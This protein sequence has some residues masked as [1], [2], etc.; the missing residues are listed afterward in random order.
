MSFASFRN[1]LV[2]ILL[3]N[4]VGR[5][6]QPARPAPERTA[7][8]ALTSDPDPGPRLRGAALV[9]IKLLP[10]V[11]SVEGAVDPWSLF[12]GDQA[13]G[14]DSRAR[15]TARFGGRELLAGIRV[16]GR[17]EGKLQVTASFGDPAHTQPLAGLSAID[18]SSAQPD[19]WNSFRAAL[20]AP[21][22]AVVIEWQPA[23]P[24]ARL[25]ELELWG[26]GEGSAA[27]P[28]LRRADQLLQGLPPGA[29]VTR[30]VP[31]EVSISRP[32]AAL[33][34]GAGR[35][36]ARL[37]LDPRA[38]GRAFLVYEL[39][40]LSGWA[41]AS[42]RINAQAALGPRLAPEATQ[43]E[44]AMLQVEE[45][46]LAALRRG[47]N[48]IQFLPVSETDP[49][50]YRVQ[51]AR[52]VV[53]PDRGDPLAGGDAVGAT[54]ARLGALF[55][56]NLDTSVRL[57]AHK[58]VMLPFARPAQPESISFYLPERS[59]GALAVSGCRDQI[60]CEEASIELDGLGVGWHT[61][62]LALGPAQSLQVSLGGASEPRGS[63]AELA[64]A[65]SGLP[66]PEPR[67]VLATPAGGQCMRTQAYV[68]GFALGI[69]SSGDAQLSLD[70]KPLALGGDGAFE[71]LVDARG[72]KPHAI[73]LQL[74]T[75][76]AR[77]QQTL[78]LGPCL[79]PRA[80]APR[81][82][83]ED[84]GA[85]FAKWVHAGEAATVQL[86]DAR[87]D[88]PAGAVAEDVRITI[89]PLSAAEA[90]PLDSG[91]TNVGPGGGAYRLG[92]HGLTF[93]KPVRLTL[94]YG[95]LPPGSA[96][97]E[98]HTF[99]FDEGAG[100][101]TRVLRAAAPEGG[102]TVA[103]TQHFTDFIN[104]TLAVPD[105]PQAASFNPTS[106]KEMK[107]GDPS[108][109]VTL[110]QPPAA[111][112]SGG[113][114]L[115]Y[116][117]EVPRGR[118]GIEPNLAVS[119]G[120]ERQNGWLGLGWD[121]HLS[122]IQVDTRFG[123]PR[124]DGS[125]T[126][127]L[128]G[129]MLAPTGAVSPAGGRLYQRRVEGAFERIERFGT[130]PT[131]YRFVVTDKSGLRRTY[132]KSPTTRL[133][134]PEAGNIFEWF[135]ERVEDPFGNFLTV[136]YVTDA[137]TNGD[138]Y[139]Q[140]GVGQPFVQVY[141]DTIGYTAHT[142]TPGGT[143][144]L[145]AHYSVRFVL[146]ALQSGGRAARPDVIITARPGFQVL[147]RHRL[148]HVE[149]RFDAQVV[150][151]YTFEYQTGEFGKSL[152][153]A[154]AMRGLDGTHEMYR[155][156]FEYFAMDRVG[157]ALAG[158]EDAKLFNVAPTLRPSD[159]LSRT[160]DQTNGGGG[161]I[162]IGIGP[163]SLSAGGGAFGGDDSTR[164]GVYVVTGD[165]LPGF[166]DDA[167]NAHV[168]SLAPVTGGLFATYTP[169]FLTGV[170]DAAIG[171]TN[172]SGW[173]VDGSLGVS[174]IIGLGASY[175]R[176]KMEDDKILVDMDGDGFVDLISIDGGC[177]HVLLNDHGRGFRPYTN[178][179]NGSACWGDLSRAQLAPSHSDRAAAARA[180]LFLV[181]PLVR[182]V[183]PIDGDVV[184]TGA[185]QKIAAGGDGVRAQI[186]RDNSLL[187]QRQVTQD[188][189]SACV[190]AG[191]NGCGAGLG[192][193]VAAGD[194]LY[195]KTSA[196]DDTTK[197]DLQ[198]NPTITY[199][200]A[201]ALSSLRE[202]DG[203][204]IYR[205]AQA[206][207]H[208]LAG[209]PRAEWIAAAQGSVHIRGQLTKLGTSDDVVLEVVKTSPPAAPAVIFSTPLLAAS[210]TAGT[211]P[212]DV[213]GDLTV[214]QGDRLELR[215]R[216]EASFDPDRAR[217][218]AEIDY[219]NFC[220]S[221]PA[222]GPVCGPVVCTA[223][224]GKVTCRIQ[225]DPDPN[226]RLPPAVIAQTA[227]VRYPA[228]VWRSA[229][230]FPQQATRAFVAPSSG[231]HAITGTLFPDP[232]L[233]VT[234]LVQGVHRLFYK[235]VFP[236]GL[237]PTPIALNIDAA[238][239]DELI[240][241]VYTDAPSLGPGLILA[242]DGAD[243]SD[244]VNR[245]HRDPNLQVD[246][247]TQ[248]AQNPM[249]GGWHRF[250]FGD[251]DGNLAFDESQ[252]VL[253]DPSSPPN[254]LPFAF[255]V[256]AAQ[257]TPSVAARLWAGRGDAYIAAGQQ[258]PSRLATTSEM[259]A[260]GGLKDLRV[261]TT[262]NVQLS[263]GALS[264]LNFDA[265]IGDSNTELDFIDLNGDGYPDSI[266]SDGV[267]FNDG[268]GGFAPAAG[269]PGLG[270]D[271]ALRQVV[272][273]SA[274]V[275]AGGSANMINLGG[276]SAETKKF[277]SLEF[278]AGIDY[279]LS[280]TE[281]DLVDLNGDGL[282]DQ[283]RTDSGRVLVRLNLGYRFGQEF[284]WPRGSWST[285]RVQDGIGAALVDVFPGDLGTDGGVRLQDTGSNSIGGGVGI[286][287]I[288]SAGEGVTFTIARSYT[289]LADINGD[290]L[291]DQLM[292]LPGSPVLLV[293]LNLGDHFDVERPW[294]VPVSWGTPIDDG[295]YAFFDS[296]QDALAFRRSESY[297]ASASGGFCIG[298]CFGGSAFHS[299]GSGSAHMG[300]ED[301]DGDGKLDFVL[302][303]DGE[304]NLRVKLNRVGKSNLLKVVHRPV[305][306]QFELEY[307]R[308][309]NHIADSDPSQR[310][311]MPHERWVLSQ[312]TTRDGMGT[313]YP[314]HIDYFASGFYDRQEREDYG[315]AHVR[316][317]REDGSTVEQRYHNQDYYR[318]GLL[319]SQAEAD[320]AGRLFLAT[321]TQYAEPG[322]QPVRTGSFFPAALVETTAFYEGTTNL[323]SAP[324][325]TMQTTKSY[326]ALGNLVGMVDGGDDGSA[327]DVQYTIGYQQDLAA[328]II[329]ASSIVARDAN[330]ALLRERTA[331]YRPDGALDVLSG[332]LMGGINPV[333]GT[334]YTG[335]SST[336]PTWHFD[337]DPLG[338]RTRV[339]DPKGFVVIYQYDPTVGTYVIGVAD[340]FG[341]TSSATYDLRF[342]LPTQT[343][344]LNGNA[345]QLEFDEFGRTTAT[346]GP[347]DIGQAEP[348][349][350]F[351][352]GLAPGVVPTWART[353]H[354][355]VANPGDPIDTVTF[356]DGLG[357]LIQTKK[358][359]ER[360]NG[361]GGTTV[362]MS[363]SGAVQFDV[364]GR[365][366][367]QGQ[368]TF[369]T[370][371]ALAFVNAPPLRPTQFQY[372]ILGR[373]TQTTA[374]DA[375]ITRIDYGFDMLDGV[376]R[377]AMTTTDAN[378]KQR[379][380]LSTVRKDTAAVVQY[381][382]GRALT[383][384]YGYDPLSE[385][386]T[387]TDA[388][389][390]A[391][392]S[393]FDTLGQRIALDNPDSGRTEY[394][395]D[396]GGN[397]AA[398]QTAKLRALGQM[399]NYNYT[400]N[401]L[402]GIDYPERTDVAYQYGAPG[403]TDNSAGRI[404]QITDESGT[405]T[406]SY[407]KLGEI[408]RSARALTRRT[409]GQAPLAAT[410]QYQ[411]DSFGRTL[412][413]IY[414]DGE[415]LTNQYD[416]GGLLTRVTGVKA[417]ASFT[418]VDRLTYDEFEQRTSI[419]YG[420]GVE[421][422]YA[423]DPLMRRLGEVRTN[424]PS[425]PVQLLH[426]GYDPVGNITSRTNDIPIPPTN[427]YGGPSAQ[428]FQY[429]DRYQLVGATG[430]YR[431]AP[432]KQQRYTL[433]M[434]YDD[435]G[436]I[437][438][439]T[440]A[441]AVVQPSG[442]SVP[443][444]GTTYDFAYAYADRPHAPAH[445]GTRTYH[446]D[447]SGNQT[448]WD[449]D[450][451][452]QRR[453]AVWNEDNQPASITDDGHE[454]DF[455]YDAAGRRTHEY[456]LEGEAIYVNQFYTVKNGTVLTKHVFAGAQR[457]ASKRELTG[458]GPQNVFR[459]FYHP[460]QIGSTSD[461]TDDQGRIYQHEE[462]FP[463]GESWIS[464]HSTT[465]RA[466][467]LFSGKE[468]DPELALYYYGARYYDPRTSVWQNVDPR[469]AKSKPA[470]AQPE[471]LAV[472]SFVRQNPLGYV[473]P[474][475]EDPIFTVW[476]V[477]KKG[478]VDDKILKQAAAGMQKTLNDIAAQSSN[479]AVKD[480]FAVKILTNGKDLEKEKLRLG[481]TDFV[482]YVQD[483]ITEEEVN[484]VFTRH[485]FSLDKDDTAKTVSTVNSGMGINWTENYEKSGEV[486]NSVS[487]VGTKAVNNT[488]P[489]L[490]VAGLQQMMTHEAVGHT[491]LGQQHDWDDLM[492]AVTTWN[493]KRPP[494]TFFTPDHQ[495]VI[496]QYLEG[497][498]QEKNK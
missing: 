483:K 300:L 356:V 202:A 385:L 363:V 362:G 334:P 182:W 218:D 457:V 371:P 394:R 343:V 59:S 498:A 53:I 210:T 374:P 399:I 345:Q 154:I 163:L 38:A 314:R 294:A 451:N 153:S 12:D 472:F 65:A 489:D 56:S 260:G 148:D 296:T 494:K 123:V 214:A 18:L 351:E 488:Y 89:R 35:L 316:T 80:P 435:I 249:S 50:G 376:R 464:E 19:R 200:V 207:D 77:S 311:D 33:V 473:D 105:H 370:G 384:R 487:F 20:A 61:V 264:V 309:G 39:Q 82:P 13:T 350:A 470:D 125:E 183:A 135:V 450:Q 274:G 241:T 11:L 120:S 415:V 404:V 112:S 348:T 63:I 211:V 354:K 258:K 286:P 254:P 493:P 52:L 209:P 304:P 181:D 303:K 390:H 468:L 36:E 268:Q 190:P 136:S 45:I 155:H 418:Y 266:A 23:R 453:T 170:D 359:L 461:V 490:K 44:Q 71:A 261:A 308:E 130:G 64:V 255:A 239:G 279:G 380:V 186:Y 456:N 164:M 313:S 15:I 352:Y 132:G 201:P 265:N 429:D 88:I 143:A 315:F 440:Q 230:E 224:A 219:T 289:E 87:L 175:T 180:R 113:A 353:R 342:G 431:E 449:D 245:R 437:T 159:G 276:T 273:R 295:N 109:G 178:P 496:L 198:W 484:T 459:F 416:R 98:I 226:L 118:G 419:R 383:T 111:S 115:S 337:Y 213:P 91:L 146:D 152:L 285:S 330:G 298:I 74:Q 290:G 495:K 402:D 215:V 76:T 147:T 478:A 60:H 282:P 420:N 70:G 460:D 149:M 331:H 434:S 173:H 2:A 400:F 8:R 4:L 203:S 407:G 340:S 22:D 127:L 229:E 195:F 392:Q 378:G 485:N 233:P 323:P 100:R 455:R 379:K 192:L 55:D 391:T 360:D 250:W 319:Q 491:I 347:Y 256:P 134:D 41:A 157:G 9:E 232:L 194:R 160:E 67:L 387:M 339:T 93:K 228:F 369:D 31:D 10:S 216:S 341:Y 284:E 86:G 169:L 16:F 280:Q 188:D 184:I 454:T 364:R 430:I 24:G 338:N 240:F 409:T 14:I 277:L 26:I 222:T 66:L 43:R 189:L 466:V 46:P 299:E 171:H 320:A 68:R 424:S 92:P 293:K 128:D 292:R 6:R 252:I 272:N 324:G 355:D 447:P 90:P 83:R 244:R 69:P 463:F 432:G 122:S 73:S 386:V 96:A 377:L 217:W 32:E 165:G 124:Y 102:R 458:G 445:I 156:S 34:A 397:V 234:L 318:H 328:Y 168:S 403:A 259:P 270:V 30:A 389:G 137:G 48:V 426:F 368:P 474:D 446:Y 448:G 243:A 333:T 144:D 7:P 25:G 121:L 185:L 310:E 465:D 382:A 306:G 212:F 263:V 231:T 307:A 142:Q 106:I 141:P 358:D 220:R 179:V 479:K 3:A 372:D 199:Q 414:P 361:G 42:R 247:G 317:T 79:P 349:I 469:L 174:G 365:I 444:G 486:A 94:P 205:F 452:G 325:K 197:D 327:D 162:G 140:P 278:N 406:R 51:H 104:A 237:L 158:F 58:Q 62:S 291:P 139:G 305:G 297:T 477:G 1:T 108:A 321:T 117:L 133:V 145:S 366:S 257:G 417:G 405:E 37:D 81:G 301:I 5:T 206:D 110:I 395:Y 114:N 166:L 97:R 204:S 411:Y 375:T 326:D 438:H 336:N 302:K 138:L 119:Y 131:D 312:V 433:S 423:Y 238:A 497:V 413:M 388:N 346:R 443:Q 29:I 251:W 367:A 208:R 187:W 85:P 72:P 275:N 322:S 28:D 107:L 412:S 196:I 283:I 27:R 221:N 253:P 393:T 78:A 248:V 492:E 428:T 476:V 235:Q 54:D 287:G 95:E 480:G 193:H 441:D 398:I 21:V 47:E 281:V 267:R 262:W 49:I 425:A 242:I 57:R 332:T 129:A 99:Y 150:R 471:L 246:D 410:S 475:G 436:N 329:H 467:Y 421:T 167:G 427:V 103:L 161:S 396:L 101:W 269:V 422:R 223:V 151:S 381:S 236:P 373:Q 481:K 177:V 408:V 482:V 176:T 401:R 344:D 357:R 191:T 84:R 17:A 288:V 271:G 225:N 442:T 462:Y 126:Y 227:Q 335:D 40:G 116:P 172:R 75:T 439:K